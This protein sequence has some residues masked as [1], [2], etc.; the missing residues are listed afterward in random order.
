MDWLQ[1]V[2]GAELE[3]QVHNAIEAYNA[4]PE[5]K[6]KQIKLGNLG[7][8]AYVSRSKYDSDLAAR[9]STIATLQGQIGTKDTDLENLRGQLSSRDTD[10]ENLQ[11]QMSAQQYNYAVKDA[12]SG[13][14]FSSHAAQKAFTDSL[15]Q[16]GLKL[17]DDKLVGFEDYVAEYK[18]DDPGAF[19]QDESA[20]KDPPPRF[21]G[22]SGGTQPEAGHTFGFNFT[23]VREKPKTN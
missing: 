15:T 19:L 8:G 7:T 1:E 11:G 17:E 6:E 13:L 14:R 22:S 20:S 4:R 16:K 10:L 21:M 23:G 9:D 3:A 12:I 18:N 2:L 5:N